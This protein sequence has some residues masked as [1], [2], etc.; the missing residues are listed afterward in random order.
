MDTTTIRI[1]GDLLRAFLMNRSGNKRQKAI[2]AELGCSKWSLNR[3][4]ASGIRH[5]SHEMATKLADYCG[6]TLE[7]LEAECN[8]DKAKMPVVGATP[9]EQYLVETYRRLPPKE[10]DE[11][12]KMILELLNQQHA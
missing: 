1:D 2:A 8:P 5:I 7:G 3:W 12:M 9:A 6:V 10:Q 4:L 11:A